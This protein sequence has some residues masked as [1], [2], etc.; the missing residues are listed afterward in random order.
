MNKNWT[1]HVENL[2][3]IE[4][5]DVTIAPLMCFVGDNNSGKSYLMSILWGILTLGKDIFPK[6]P[7]E[8]KVY[9]QCENWLKDRI[10]IDI[11]LSGTDMQLY[12]DWFNELLNFQKKTLVKRIFNYDVEI[13]KLKITDYERNKPIK[14]IWEKAGSRYSVTNNYIKFPEVD[15]P[16]RDELFRMN[17]YIC[18]NLLMEGIAAPLYT[19]IVKGRRIG[20]PIYLPAS[21]TGFMLT[22]AQLIEN[23]LQISFSQDLHENTS[24]LTLPYVDFLQLITKFEINKKDSKKYTEIIEYIEKN[25][26]KGNLSIKKDMLPVIKYQ[27]EGSDKEIPLYVASSIVSEISPLLLVLK[28]G[29]N[30]KAMIIEE[31]EAHL[32]PEL[33]Q[34]MARLIINMVN[35]GIPVWITTHSDTILQ[36]ITNMMKLKNPERSVELQQEYGYKKTDLLGKEDIQMYQFVTE[37]SRKTRLISLEATKYGFVVPTFNDALEKIVDEVYAFQED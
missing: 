23:S 32:H 4:S 24:T 8:A 19:P 34:K 37:N 16:S 21:R 1:L 10:N 35:L 27:P 36:H 20:E 14:I 11:E 12:V 22:Y 5:A 13:E 3:K 15:S 31:P 6:K 33:Q 29:I 26:T 9:K 17:A 7:S 28:S 25:M 2:A 30:F 18:W